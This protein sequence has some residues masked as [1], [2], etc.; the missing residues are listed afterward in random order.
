MNRT[1]AHD[2]HNP[3]GPGDRGDGAAPDAAPS[4]ARRGTRLSRLVAPAV[5]GTAGLLLVAAVV[6]AVSTL[7][8]PVPESAD[9]TAPA[10]TVATDA[11]DAATSGASTAAGSATTSTG[12]PESTRTTTGPT[13]SAP[14]GTGTT[15]AGEGSAAKERLNQIAA[16]DENRPQGQAYAILFDLS[17]GGQSRSM[18]TES[19][20]STWT[21]SDILWLYDKRVAAWPGAVLQARPDGDKTSWRLTVSNPSWRSAA[22]AQKWCDTSFAQYDGDARSDRCHVPGN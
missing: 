12:S 9:L 6:Q 4:G 7:R 5:L 17:D 18:K 8:T 21:A 19:G 3:G 16:R 2:G 22:D 11:A 15:S 14:T 20:S 13:S 1:G 10:A